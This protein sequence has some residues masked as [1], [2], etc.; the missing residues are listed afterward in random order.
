VCVCGCVLNFR[1]NYREAL[2]V[3]ALQV[4]K[5]PLTMP[6]PA[7][8]G[9]PPVSRGRFDGHYPAQTAWSESEYTTSDGRLS[10]LGAF[11][12]YSS[13]PLHSPAARRPPHSPKI[14]LKYLKSVFPKAEETYLLHL[15]SCS[16]NNV[17]DVTE[18]L[19]NLGHQKKD[20]PQPLTPRRKLLTTPPVKVKV[21]PLL[22]P[23]ETS[24]KNLPSIAGKIIMKNELQK[25]FPEVDEPVIQLAMDSADYDLEK[26]K[27]ILS[28][29][30]QRVDYSPPPKTMSVSELKHTLTLSSLK[31]SPSMMSTLK[32]IAA[33]YSPMKS[34]HVAFNEQVRRVKPRPEQLLPVKE[35]AIH[36]GPNRALLSESY[37]TTEGPSPNLA[38]GHDSSLRIK[39]LSKTGERVQVQGNNPRN[40]QGAVADSARGSLSSLL[41]RKFM[42]DSMRRI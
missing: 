9:T 26:A 17:T 2:V 24:P 12:N 11:S 27:V 23:V 33:L 14:K 30:R 39:C 32:D 21:T 34:D 4:M 42:P 31:S 13:T 20:H 25:L 1:Y 8:V 35:N 38:K 37:E 7:T 6:G 15:L 18:Q 3:S 16:D 10:K 36:A 28:S 41:S 19:L 40:R 29:S 5:Y 22:P